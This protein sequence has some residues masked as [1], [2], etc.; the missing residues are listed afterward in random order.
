MRM[1]DG[2]DL[3]LVTKDERRLIRAIAF[4]GSAMMGLR[5]VRTP[6]SD[7]M[8]HFEH[9]LDTNPDERLLTDV[10]NE[11]GLELNLHPD[12]LVEIMEAAHVW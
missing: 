10:L 7:E 11:I 8:A 3:T 1:G 12:T 2:H 5:P 4:M 6:L 9:Q